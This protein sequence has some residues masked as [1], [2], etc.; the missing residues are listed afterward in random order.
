MKCVLENSRF[1][2]LAG[3][4]I[5]LSEYCH[6]VYGTHETR[7]SAVNWLLYVANQ[8]RETFGASLALPLLHEPW[9]S[10]PF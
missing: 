6:S 1:L 7:L 3:N 5:I 2:Q 9:R 10:W 4:W 8:I